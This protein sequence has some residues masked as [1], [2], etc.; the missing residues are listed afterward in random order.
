MNKALFK[1]II[2]ILSLLPGA[3][4]CAEVNYVEVSQKKGVYHMHIIMTVNADTDSIKRIITDYE[5]LTLT[6]PYIKE[7]ELINIS[8]DERTTV[9]MLTKI[10]IF[11]ICYNI[12]HVQTFHPV[13]NGVLYSRI[14]PGMSDFKSGWLRWE[15]KEKD[16]NRIS[17]VTQIIFD[18]E[19]TPDFFIPPVIGPYQMKKKMFEIAKDTI[20][21]LEKKAKLTSFH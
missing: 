21:N 7:S 20:N 1:M 3:S 14:I 6:N 19:I 15:I 9:S 16:S 10:C 4:L 17:P 2:V 13:N 12:R 18:T 5:N 8:E 11:L